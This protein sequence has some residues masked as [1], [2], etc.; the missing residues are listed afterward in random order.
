[1]KDS[2]VML[3]IKGTYDHPRCKWSRRLMHLIFDHGVGRF[4]YVDILG[5]QDV[6]EGLKVYGDNPQKT[7]PQV[8]IHG[9]LLGGYEAFKSLVEDRK[10]FLETIP[11]ECFVQV[12]PKE[13]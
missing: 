3:F 7:F 9:K 4:G 11:L 1:M 8:W 13:V 6:R 5:D 2:P 12:S 10:R